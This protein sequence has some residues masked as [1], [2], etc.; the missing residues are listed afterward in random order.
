MSRNPKW[1]IDELIL[2]LDLYFVFVCAPSSASHPKVVEISEILN[3]LPIHTERPDADRFRNPNGVAMKLS[4]YLRLDP[5]YA[6]KGLVSGGKLEE[7]V[8]E[9]Y[10]NRSD[11]LRDIAN[12]IKEIAKS[13]CGK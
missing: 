2:A 9:M 11:E 7:K 5:T 3:K 6:G 8:W 1:H 12:K 13:T 4:N 10:H